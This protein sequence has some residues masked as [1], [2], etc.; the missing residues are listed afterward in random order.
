MENKISTLE[1]TIPSS[2]ITIFHQQATQKI[3][4]EGWAKQG[5]N[6]DVKIQNFINCWTTEEAFKQLLIQRK[7][8]F[9]NRGLYFGD[10]QGAGADFTVK[11]EGE[12]VTIGLR[13]VS[14]ESLHNWKSVAYPNDRFEEEQDNA[15]KLEISGTSRPGGIADYH[16]VCH[17]EN[18]TVQFLGIISKDS[19]I[20]ALENSPVLY[21]RKNQEKF[22]VIPLERFEFEKLLQLLEKIER[23]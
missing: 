11:I 15:Q 8:W 7:V 22:R 19:L 4:S 5:R 1:Q 2:L 3:Q 17:Q 12:E 16:I 18:G 20:R 9:R 13:S 23:V 14:S 21:S 6:V 10:A